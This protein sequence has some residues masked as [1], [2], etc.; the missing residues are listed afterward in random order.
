MVKNPVFAGPWPSRRVRSSALSFYFDISPFHFS[1]LLSKLLQSKPTQ[2]AIFEQFFDFEFQSTQTWTQIRTT[3]RARAEIKLEF[4][5]EQLFVTVQRAREASAFIKNNKRRRLW[6]PSDT[7]MWWRFR[8]GGSHFLKWF[9]EGIFSKIVPNGAQHCFKNLTK[10]D[11]KTNLKRS[12]QK[13]LK[14]C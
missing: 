4:E 3:I 14:V 11:K 12:P 13:M 6:E 9:S 5:F 2:A 10:S 8:V 7:G 1:V